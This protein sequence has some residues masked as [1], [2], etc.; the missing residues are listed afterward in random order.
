VIADLRT[1]A[2]APGAKPAQQEQLHKTANYFERNLEYMHYDH[3]YRREQRHRRLYAS[4]RLGSSRWNIWRLTQQ[5]LQLN[6]LSLSQQEVNISLPPPN[7]NGQPNH[8][9]T[10]LGRTQ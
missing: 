8:F 3:A 7:E 4:P 1:L 6:I 10:G 2:Q 9:S 5:H